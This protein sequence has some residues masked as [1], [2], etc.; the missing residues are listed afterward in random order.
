MSVTMLVTG[1]LTTTPQLEL[2]RGML[3]PIECRH[4]ARLPWPIPVVPKHAARSRVAGTFFKSGAA[5]TI[6]AHMCC[7]VIPDPC[8]MSVHQVAVVLVLV[9]WMM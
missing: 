2:V 7:G 1:L 6:V 4:Y 8:R 5:V 3:H 9:T